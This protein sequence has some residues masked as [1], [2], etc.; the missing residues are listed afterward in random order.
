MYIFLCPVCGRRVPFPEAFRYEGACSNRHYREFV[1]MMI[2]LG[3]TLASFQVRLAR[4]E[5][6]ESFGNVADISRSQRFVPLT[7]SESV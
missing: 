4:E 7:E 3:Q 5:F 1:R 6:E 2:S